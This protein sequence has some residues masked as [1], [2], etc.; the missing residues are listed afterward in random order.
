[1]VDFIA[2]LGIISVFALVGGIVANRFGQPTVLG[3]LITGALIG[4]NMLGL[5]AHTDFINMLAEIGAVLLLFTIGIE[6]SLG[7]LLRCGL[8]AIL[9]SVLKISIVFVATYETALLAGLSLFES[10]VVGAIF[11][12]T[13]TAIVARMLSDKGIKNRREA[14]LLIATLILEDVFAIFLLAF[15]SSGSASIQSSQDLF[16]PFIIALS[17]LAL[18]YVLLQRV[19]RGIVCWILKYGT[20]ESLSLAAV[21]M[22]IG[23]SYAAAA[24]GLA[25]SIGA[26]VAGSIVMTLPSG[27]EME[28]RIK[29]FTSVFTALFFLTMGMFVKPLLLLQNLPLLLTLLIIT[30][31]SK[32][33]GMGL[34]TYFVGLGGKSAVFA[35]LAMIPTGEFSLLL[36]REASELVSF[37]IVGITSVIVLMSAVITSEAINRTE[38][39]HSLIINAMPYGLLL[40]MLEISRYFGAVVRNFEPGGRF[41]LAFIHNGKKLVANASLLVVMGGGIF[42]TLS[43]IPYLPPNNTY[44]FFAYGF[45]ALIVIASIFPLITIINALHNILDE[46]ADSFLHARGKRKQLGME[47]MRNAILLLFCLVGATYLPFLLSILRLEA[48]KQLSIIPLFVSALLLW[49]IARHI[50]EVFIRRR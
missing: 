31:L 24:L 12:V 47:I 27:G 26:F 40:R 25:P 3:L 17:L 36:A 30:T 15:F 28:K 8:R 44:I 43:L 50:H 49:D 18:V 5:V 9:V 7:K 38:F 41:F 37:D 48:F 45:I 35:G 10:L 22:A 42:L 11:S 29:P 13:S 4:P 19:L 16:L 1:M 2:E 46:L 14:N 34:S 21:A 23:L 32:F 39:I 20:D 33:F 6:F